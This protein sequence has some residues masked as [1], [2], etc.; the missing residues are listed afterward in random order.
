MS[1]DLLQ[2]HAFCLTDTG[3]RLDQYARAIARVVRPGDVVVDL[4][5]GTGILSFLSCAAGAQRV[6]AIEASE[7]IAYGEA[8]AA[9]AGWADR[10][11]FINEPSS[12][13]TLS[14]RADVIVADIHDTFGLQAGGLGAFIDA[15]DRLLKPGSRVI[16]SSLDLFVAPIEAHDAYR[17]SVDL[18]RQRIH[19]ID[20]SPLRSLAVNQKHPARFDSRQLIAAPA[21]LCTVALTT[22]DTPHVGGSARMTVARSGTVH[23]I[24]GSFVTTLAEGVAIGNLPGDSATTNFAQAFFPIDAP[25][26]VAAGDEISIA[27]DSFDSIQLRWQMTVESRERGTSMCFDHSTFHSTPMR[28][29]ALDK[30]AD[31]YRPTLTARGAM[32]REL[33]DRFDGTTSAADLERWLLQRLGTQ[34][35]SAREAAAFLK[36]TIDRCG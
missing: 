3:T 10:V 14:E 26:A 1:S 13:V 20:L 23:G 31:N 32:E 12:Q 35:P 29:G 30:R 33:L 34:L 21:A 7:A 9:S 19:G 4:G 16:P 11:R 2:F 6:H 17:R 24:C 8:L 25:V 36:S 22:I 5:A 15:R 27:V 28:L 18:W